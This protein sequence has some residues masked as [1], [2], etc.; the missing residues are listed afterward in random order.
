MRK[1]RGFVLKLDLEKTFD[2]INWEF[3]DFMLRK[4]N[5]PKKRR[6]WIQVSIR[7]VQ[8][9]V[10]INEKPYGRIKPN[11]GIRQ[12]DPISPFTFILVMNYLSSLL[13]FL[14][15]KKATKGVV[16]YL[17]NHILFADDILIIT[18]DDDTSIKNLQM[19]IFLF[20]KASGIT[21]NHA[22][23]TLTTINVTMEVANNIANT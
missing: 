8:C 21:I 2:T 18:K 7:N 17:I 23:S 12:G 22:K 15:D 1:I 9:L 19:V 11:R 4:K 20:E 6:K 14:Q 10:L 5:Y 13:N 16:Q 3:L